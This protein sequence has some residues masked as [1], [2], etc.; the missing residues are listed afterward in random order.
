MSMFDFVKRSNQL[1]FGAAK[2]SLKD[3]TKDI[4]E[5]GSAA[6]QVREKLSS[7]TRTARDTMAGFKSRGIVSG[8]SNWFYG[9]EFEMNDADEA[10][11]DEDSFDSGNPELNADS[12]NAEP[13][14]LTASSMK[15]LV[16]GQV[17]S[18]YKIGSKQTE[19]SIANTAEIV[20]S[21]SK[22]SAEIIAA[23]NNVNSS[24]IT[25]SGK[26]DGLV[27]LLKPQ[28]QEQSNRNGS[29]FN[30]NGEFTIRSIMEGFKNSNNM[31]GSLGYLGMASSLLS[32][33]NMRKMFFTPE[34]LVSM[35]VMDPLKRNVNVGGKSIDQWGNQ[36]QEFTHNMVQDAIQSL[37]EK[38]P[39][40]S[41]VMGTDKYRGNL[42]RAENQYTKEA[43]VFDKATRHS[44][45]SVIPEYLKK[46]TEAVTGQKWNINEQGYLTTK[47]QSNPYSNIG[48]VLNGASLSYEKEEEINRLVNS[49]NPNID[50]TDSEN[51]QKAWIWV[52]VHSIIY[53]GNRKH[54]TAKNI[55]DMVTSPRLEEYISQAEQIFKI[56]SSGRQVSNPRKILRDV[57]LV[58]ASNKSSASALASAGNKYMKDIEN[59]AEDI[60]ENNPLAA[61]YV[62]QS[63]L[64]WNTSVNNLKAN[65]GSVQYETEKRR[66]EERM[67]RE[68]EESWKSGTVRPGMF[69]DSYIDNYVQRKSEEWERSHPSPDKEEEVTSRIG[70]G[71]S[72][73][74]FSRFI[75]D[76]N[77]YSK[78]IYDILN[79]GVVNVRIVT[80]NVNQQ[81]NT[82]TRRV[83]ARRRRATVGNESD[84]DGDGGGD[85]GHPEDV[86][87]TQP[88][89]DTSGSMCNSNDS[90]GKAYAIGHYLAKCSITTALQTSM[91]DG[92]G[93]EDSAK[94]RQLISKIDDPKLKQEMTKAAESVLTK[95]NND[96]KEPKQQSFLGKLL[97]G[98]G[99]KFV[100]KIK[101]A[102]SFVLKPF[103]AIFS[104]IKTLIMKYF[105]WVKKNLNQAKTGAGL[106]KRG[107]SGLFQVHKYNKAIKNGEDILF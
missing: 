30:E 77:K 35:F 22:S 58:I 44:I 47:T 23:V 67:R 89:V 90:I 17:S 13:D 99:A 26:L 105:T 81:R 53:S 96:G 11:F 72:G 106:I 42:G 83:V 88:I 16:K 100:P 82:R 19:A 15:E 103:T 29:W 62:N 45:I 63:R 85:A 14:A 64:D 34:N 36:F 101:T 52:V 92:D 37:I 24:L 61:Q 20:T 5:L 59:S 56:Y 79:E 54:I 51:A 66:Y 69:K 8:I 27:E 70:N 40:G 4:A 71:N 75:E 93:I 7:T 9:K 68:A 76:M 38:T 12:E 84:A 33:P 65:Q 48:N 39:F 21:I 74:G 73:S 78:S 50:S 104:G 80:S 91:Q 94:V 87:D 55:V 28:R 102:L 18:M 97:T 32:D 6:N 49:S 43:A 10:L 31:S 46:L 41:M 2:E 57:L 107:V 95:E 60:S 1:M 86:A 3:Y 98:L 25:I